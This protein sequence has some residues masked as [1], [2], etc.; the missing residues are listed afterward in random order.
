MKINIK[1]LLILLLVFTILFLF[2]GLKVFDN[3]ETVISE[4][5]CGNNICET[6]EEIYCLD[7]NISCKSNLCNNKIQIIIENSEQP[8]ANKFLENQNKVYK[9]LSDY[10]KNYPKRIISYTIYYNDT[11][12]KDCT[13]LEG[14]YINSGKFS[15]S[16][17]IFLEFIPGFLEYEE[18]KIR[19]AENVGFEVHEMSHAFTYYLLGI[20]P[21]W[22]D[23]G[24]SIYAESRFG[25]NG[26]FNENPMNEFMDL[27]KPNNT[28]TTE[29]YERTIN[30]PHVV[31]ALYFG[32]LE[33][34]YN[35]NSECVSEILYSLYSYRQN[36]TKSDLRTEVI[37]NK[38]IKQKSEEAIGEDLTELFNSL[39]IAY[40]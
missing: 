23:E 16:E 7:C 15:R 19:K 13:N 25:C 24:V 5:F 11:D 33:K 9:C 36:Y 3:N 1:E 34:D 4:S 26:R 21:S 35:C 38:M 6:N 31:G 17:G 28:L 18:S 14:C 32:Y 22:F 40:D 39:N 10:Y 27:Y 2:L 12:I 8:L 29:E 37:T 30:S 20:V